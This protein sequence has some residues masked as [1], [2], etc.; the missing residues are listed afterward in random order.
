MHSSDVHT[1][2]R[3]RAADVTHNCRAGS[4]QKAAYEAL[5]GPS[6]WHLRSPNLTSLHFL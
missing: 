6:P 2:S 3:L 4:K 5:Q 1:P